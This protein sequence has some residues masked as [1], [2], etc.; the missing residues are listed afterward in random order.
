MTKPHL[1]EEEVAESLLY[2]IEDWGL[3]G[4]SGEE[5]SSS[6]GGF[7]RRCRVEGSGVMILGREGNEDSMSALEGGGK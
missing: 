1:F 4:A 5:K 3:G 7:L 2:A 6:V